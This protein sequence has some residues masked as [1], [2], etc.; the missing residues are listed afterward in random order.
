MVERPKKNLAFRKL[1]MAEFNRCKGDNIANV[2]RRLRRKGY[3][4]TKVGHKTSILIRRP[5]RQRFA[6]FKEDLAELIQPRIGGL[7]LS[8][9]SGRFWRMDNTGNKPGILQRVTAEDL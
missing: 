1:Y 3:Q 2:L 6:E 4:A 8:S 7:I 9:T 5:S